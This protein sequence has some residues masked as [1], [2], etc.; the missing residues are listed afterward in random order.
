MATI[1]RMD[2]TPQ[3]LHDAEF[4]EA[5][6]G[7][8]NTQD[9]D[10]FL[11]R[12]AVGLERQ[13]GI[14]REAR[15]RI[16]AA[17][18]RAAEA[19]QR[20]AQA[21]QAASETSTSDGTLARTLVLAQRTADAAIS[22]AEEQASLTLATAQAEAERLLA[23]AHEA[24]ARARA[25]AEDEAHQAHEETRTRVLGEMR[26]METAR[27][28]LRE[29]VE[30]L[31]HHLVEQRERVRRAVDELQRTI[32]DPDSLREVELPVVSDVVVP[33]EE[34]SPAPSRTPLVAER[35][36]PEEDAPADWIPDDEVWSEADSGV[37]SPARAEA[38]YDEVDGPATQPVDMLAEHDADDDAYLTELRKAMTDDSPLGP[39]DDVSDA[40]FFDAGP[41]A[42]RSRFGRRR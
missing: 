12:L 19:E 36:S 6:R 39:R 37:P 9:V 34:S 25:E 10:E 23:E 29:D 5:K 41:E 14:V 4:R 15:Q 17:E 28:R 38:D 18:A 1:D 3:L 26:D 27:D 22:E 30:I 35:V 20:A 16:E 24:S 8:Y 7:G 21:E 33:V 40:G 31:E 42:A 13:D 11:E 32:D 2:V